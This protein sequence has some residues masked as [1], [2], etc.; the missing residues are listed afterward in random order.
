MLATRPG[1]WLQGLTLLMSALAAAALD[2]SLAPTPAPIASLVGA[3]L[4]YLGATAGCWAIGRR[5][6]QR[7]VSADCRLGW[8]VQ[9]ALAVTFV[10]PFALEPLTGWA[11]NTV[12]PE[13]ALLL[14][15]LR[16][17]GL[18]ASAGS[19]WEGGLRLGALASLCE[20]AFAFSLGGASAAAGVVAL[21]LAVAVLWLH[22]YSWDA[23]STPGGRGRAQRWLGAGACVALVMM[24]FAGALA[25][26]GAEVGA[27]E[28]WF[29]SSGGSREKHEF[30]RGGVNDGED[31]V[32]ATDRAETTGF[33]DSEVF[34]DTPD[35]TLFDV[36]NDLFGEP[37]TR[38]AQQKAV[39]LASDKVI[40]TKK[41][42][43]KSHA[44]SPEF[45]TLRRTPK[46]RNIPEPQLATALLYVRGRTPQ[47]LG[48]TAYD[49]FD[50]DVWHVAPVGTEEIQL[51]RQWRSDWFQVLDS[52]NAN[53]FRGP[54][55][56]EVRIA[57]LN[58]ASVPS[59]PHITR[60]QIR[61]VDRADMFCW[62]HE[63]LLAMD[64][65][66]IPVGTTVRVETL[67]ADESRLETA[68]FSRDSG[69]LDRYL[70]VPPGLRYSQRL[71][72]L[73]DE[74]SRSS[75]PGWGQIQSVVRLLRERCVLDS[76]AVA[77]VSGADPVHH[78]LF[79]TRRG[80]S[81]LFATAAAVI[82]R[83]LGYPTRLI[84]GFYVRPERHDAK[85][86]LSLVGAQDVHFWPQVLLDP[87]LGGVER[88]AWLTLEPTP[89]CRVLQP[90][91]TFQEWVVA[92][93][94][95]ALAMLLTHWAPTALALALCC[96]L[97]AGR[98]RLADLYLT[99]AVRVLGRR[100]ARRRILGTLRLLETRCRWAGAR[101][102]S[103]RTLRAWLGIT[104]SLEGDERDLD[105]LLHL[106]E[107]L[108]FNQARRTDAEPPAP[109]D[110]AV[111]CDSVLRAWSHNRL[112]S[113]LAPR[114][115]RQSGI[116]AARLVFRRS[117][118]GG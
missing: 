6:W 118:M 104:G 100:S 67:L 97:W 39:S 12:S 106:G 87:P 51:Q 3:C 90:R 28:G 81:Y 1:T 110:L 31:Q 78:F 108:I 107:R 116:L 103:H 95:N 89:G 17:V 72:R 75:S 61:S 42:A 60:F 113:R 56:Y 55:R 54:E 91:V 47:H 5:W 20:I 70:D 105:R 53:V 13:G 40:E 82:L 15:G 86:N 77:P 102:P 33:A 50:G 4:I 99:L 2:H 21:Y 30:A 69:L 11:A 62:S 35:F 9:A 29:P 43:P 84:S 73:V 94:R 38:R 65:R 101:R 98:L 32:A 7:Q 111:L 27:L 34:L 64:V 58:T 23:R 57:R 109:A 88:R 71:R 26:R 24:S 80:P 66:R 52:P 115:A 114:P 37:E 59:P 112:R 44:P 79:V 83:H 10:L 48:L 46:R 22:R 36:S 14:F 74:V 93:V 8:V 49:R 96:L 76:R 18:A 85:S 92:A 45:S 117:A 63:A 19:W 16:N 68:E 41:E 25:Q